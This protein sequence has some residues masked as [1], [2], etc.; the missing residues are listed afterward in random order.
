MRKITLSLVVVLIAA[1]PAAAAPAETQVAGPKPPA[2]PA[3]ALP[4]AEQCQAPTAVNADACNSLFA[5]MLEYQKMMNKEAREDRRL[6]RQERASA[7]DAKAGKIS[8]DNKAIDQGMQE[9][10]DKADTAQ[11]S[12]T[13]SIAIGVTGAIGAIA[14]ASAAPCAVT[15]KDCG[16]TCKQPPCK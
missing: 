13:T 10:R 1:G 5:T 3:A 4:T 9:S 12:A 14:P 16:K 2:V 11:R 6:Q 15:D 7:L 8:L